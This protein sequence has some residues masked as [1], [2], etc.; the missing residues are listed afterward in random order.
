MFPRISN[1]DKI[2]V[3]SLI[4]LVISFVSG[5]YAHGGGFRGG[6]RSGGFSG[7]TSIGDPSSPAYDPTL[8][9]IIISVVILIIGTV[10]VILWK[11]WDKKRKAKGMVRY[12][13]KHDAAWKLEALKERVRETFLKFHESAVKEDMYPVEN[14]ITDSLYVAR[15]SQINRLISRNHKNMV[16]NINIKNL[17]VVGVADYMDD[18]LDYFWVH[19]KGTKYDYFVDRRTGRTVAGEPY[20]LGT[21]SE[22]WKFV[23]SPKGWLADQIHQSAIWDILRMDSF[24]DGYSSMDVSSSS[25]NGYL[26]CNNCGGY[27]LLEG[28][29]S[30]EDFDVCQCGGN[31]TYYDNL[32]TLTGNKNTM[33]GRMHSNVYKFSNKDN[34]NQ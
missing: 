5:V 29:E 2:F 16:K 10:A 17:D 21:F 23:R 14:Y 9:V 7:L 19:I 1:F 15:Q 3:I 24:T 30:P 31:L 20:H 4:F 28:S 11:V 22:T 33:D 32:D 13:E 34:E 12:I 18:N 26:S 25:T 8:L 6:F 27:Y